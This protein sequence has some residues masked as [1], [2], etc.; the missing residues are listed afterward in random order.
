M[1]L[2]VITWS[3]DGFDPGASQEL[4]RAGSGPATDTVT[5]RRFHSGSLFCIVLEWRTHMWVGMMEREGEGRK[6]AKVLYHH[7][8]HHTVRNQSL[9]S[10]EELHTAF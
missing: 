8:S 10:D 7:I 9:C 3:K 1:T 4:Q 2:C 6:G 5:V